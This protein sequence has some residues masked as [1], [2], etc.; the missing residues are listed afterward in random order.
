VSGKGKQQG[1]LVLQF[2][3]LRPA[4]RKATYRPEHQ[5][6]V[7]FVLIGEEEILDRKGVQGGDVLGECRVVRVDGIMDLMSLLRL[8]GI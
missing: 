3:H 6:D 5:L 2:A 7:A 8:P 4:G 1:H